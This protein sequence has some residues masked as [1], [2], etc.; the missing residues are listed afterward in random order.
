MKYALIKST[1]LLTVVCTQTLF[2]SSL[3]ATPLISETDILKPTAGYQ[4]QRLGARIE[5]VE[6]LDSQVKIKISL[7]KQVSQS[8][9]EEVTV[10]GDPQKVERNREVLQAKRFE[11]IQDPNLDR[12]GLVI[13]LGQQQD[14]S[15]KLNYTEPS[16]PTEPDHINR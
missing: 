13:Y 16:H 5:S 4:G 15:L 6:T 14:F 12:S 2:S 11:F 9:L 8:K 3:L 10:Y 1:V 7:P